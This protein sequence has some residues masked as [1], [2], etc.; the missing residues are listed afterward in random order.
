LLAA[1]GFSLARLA[2][3]DRYLV[4]SLSKATATATI[5]IIPM[6]VERSIPNKFPS[7]IAQRLF[8]SQLRYIPSITFSRRIKSLLSFAHENPIICGSSTES[9]SKRENGE[10]INLDNQAERKPKK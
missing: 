2:N 10:P 1:L 6:M 7:A 5:I 4:K 3:F 9:N 8:N